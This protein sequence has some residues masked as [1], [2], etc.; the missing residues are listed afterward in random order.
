MDAVSIALLTVHPVLGS[1][2]VWWI[3][4]QGAWMRQQTTLRGEPLEAA[5][6]RHEREGPRLLLF[7]AVTVTVAFIADLTLREPPFGPVGL[8]VHGWLGLVI[9]SLLIVGWR[10]GVAVQRARAAGDS[11]GALRTRHGR[12]TRWLPWLALVV[13]LLGFLNWLEVI[14]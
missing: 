5:R 4:R 10:R 11:F 8:S 2:T 6:G 7:M 12:L 14:A 13:A 1:L 9:L 3:W